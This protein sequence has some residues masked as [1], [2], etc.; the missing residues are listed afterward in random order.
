MKHETKNIQV[1]DRFSEVNL[2]LLV[3][4]SIYLK[5]QIEILSAEL[6]INNDLIL[7][8]M[9]TNSIKTDQ[10]TATRVFT[11]QTTIAPDITTELIE[12]GLK[13]NNFS[14]FTLIET[15]KPTYNQLAKLVGSASQYAI[16]NQNTTVSLRITT[17][18]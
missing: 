12:D 3:H 5:T 8:Q 11:T 10:G 13:Q 18:K 14:M 4:K 16:V 7:S 2:Q 1:S 9:N 6:K 15:L 17:T